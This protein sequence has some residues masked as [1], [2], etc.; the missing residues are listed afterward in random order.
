[1]IASLQRI[2]PWM[3]GFFAYLAWRL[4]GALVRLGRRRAQPPFYVQGPV[5]V[6]QTGALGDVLMT[7][8]LLQA[9]IARLGMGEVDVVVTERTAELLQNIPGLGRIITISRPLRWRN[10]ASVLEYMR[11]TRDLRR[12]HYTIIFDTSRIFQSAWMA[13]FASRGPSAGLRLPRKAGPFMMSE[14]SYLYTHEVPV[15]PAEHMIRQNLALLK[16][17]GIGVTTERP[18]FTP[19]QDDQ[20]A[21]RTWLTK[22]GVTAD[23]EIVVVYPGT[24]W[25]P[26]RWHAERF[27]RLVEQLQSNGLSVILAGAA[28]DRPLAQAVARNVHP[29][30]LILTGVSLSTVAAL[31][32]RA[33]LFIGNDGALMHLAAAQGTPIVALFGPTLPERTGPLG[34]PALAITKPI[35]CRPCRLY[36]T[37]D[38][39]QRG[40]NYCMDLIEVEEVWAATQAL[41]RE[42]SGACPV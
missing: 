19:T 39:C 27:Q 29:A 2:L 30:P 21:A 10:P 36:H 6:L 24:K 14:F 16:P 3:N 33:S 38:T 5:C 23:R 37:R 25:P 34:A 42:R 35:G 31:I 22:H 40:H 20:H 7:T 9:L 28:E 18:W 12:H 11:T 32:K 17:F 4:G 8:P 41:L 26:K 1:M 15:D 13:C